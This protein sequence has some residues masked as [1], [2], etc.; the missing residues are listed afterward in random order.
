MTLFQFVTSERMTAR[1]AVAIMDFAGEPEG[2]ASANVLSEP[3][4]SRL[5]LLA[6]EVLSSDSIC[7]GL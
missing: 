5:R 3:D 1:Q 7:P 4:L 2:L 6:Q